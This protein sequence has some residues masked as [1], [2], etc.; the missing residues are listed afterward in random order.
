MADFSYLKKLAVSA[1]SMVEY[2]L[3][4]LAGSPVL[5][6]RPAN[7]SNSAYMNDL[8]RLTGQSNGG[9]KKKVHVDAKLLGAMRE[10][11][12]VLYPKHVI[13]GWKGMLDTAGEE[14]PFSQE[15]AA[16]FITML[17]NWIFDGV[18]EWAANPENF[19]NTIDS[20]A[21]AGN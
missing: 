16:A 9:R 2:P 5:Q 10:H 4:E 21:I 20:E 13:V 19:I 15:D 7:D 14:V 12:K 17:P 6:L 8:L 3:T 1:E 11:D 18:R